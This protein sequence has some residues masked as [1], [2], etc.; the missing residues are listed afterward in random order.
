MGQSLG[1]AN[2]TPSKEDL[3]FQ[4]VLVGNIDWVRAHC[5]TGTNLECIDKEGNTPLI[6]A[7]KY[8]ALL[9]V[10]V[11][12]I[13]LGANVNAYGPGRGGGTPLHHAASRGLEETVR[14]LLFSGGVLLVL[15]LLCLSL[16][17]SWHIEGCKLCIMLLKS[18]IVN[19]LVDIP[20]NALVRNDDGQT[21]LDFAR[22]NRNT[23]V[24]RAIEDH[25]CLFSGWLR[26]FYGPGFLK[27]FA[28]R[29]MSRKVWA[30]VLP[31]SSR[32]PTRNFRL[33]LAVYT[34]LQES[35]SCTLIPLW[36]AKIEEPKFDQPDPQMIVFDQ[37]SN[38]RYHFASSTEGDK[39]QLRL[40][41]DAC[42]GI[43][44]VGPNARYQ[45]MQHDIPDNGHENPDEAVQLAMALSASIQSA[46]E[47]VQQLPNTPHRPVA[48]NTNGWGGSAL[49]GSHNG[50]GA[51][52]VEPPHSEASSSGQTV[53]ELAK[54]NY[55]GWDD[56]PNT[57]LISSRAHS[58][59]HHNNLPA[60][61]VL[62]AAPSAPPIPDIAAINEGPI[63]YPSID[64]GLVDFSG[65]ATDEGASSSTPSMCVICWDAPVEGACVP[66][67]HMAG[68][69]ECL[70]NIQAKKGDCPV[71]RAKITQVIKL[72]AV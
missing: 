42:R 51:S 33:Q 30:V 10:A 12:L 4:F 38:I 6:V 36:K 8:S 28:P 23:V 49:P 65:P 64:L 70:G 16:V 41:Y 62:P 47:D 39:H 18:L 9:N 32:N 66:C 34:N 11:A 22:I 37:S 21:A 53:E 68:C 52:P 60:V 46:V 2:Q 72:Y 5:R 35:Q 54:E 50:W 43:T 14:L 40:L 45:H 24:V 20:A 27:A 55:N 19:C 56:F 31:F 44:Q 61:S 25:I 67:G 71:C 63:H 17:F 59:M 58:Q 7:C 29:W 1:T 26:E 57:K 48:I 15:T 13:E 69:M 3:L